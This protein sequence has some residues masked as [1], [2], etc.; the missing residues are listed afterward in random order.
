MSRPEPQLIAPRVLLRFLQ[1]E[2][3]KCKKTIADLQGRL[4]NMQV[5]VARA[6]AWISESMTLSIFLET[7]RKQ[8]EAA[9]RVEDDDAAIPL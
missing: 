5:E 7:S 6:Q 4:R 9:Q 8:L 3:D 2:Q 1:E